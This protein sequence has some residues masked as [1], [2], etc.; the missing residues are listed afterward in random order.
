MAD[1]GDAMQ[2][3]CAGSFPSNVSTWG[4][5]L[6]VLEQLVFV[7]HQLHSVAHTRLHVL[8]RH[9]SGAEDPK[10][11]QEMDLLLLRL[12]RARGGPDTEALTPTLAFYLYLLTG[13]LY[14]LQGNLKLSFNALERALSATP[15]PGSA[16]ETRFCEYLNIRL[17]CLLGASL[18]ELRSHWEIFVLKIHGG[19]R[20]SDIAARIWTD[21]ILDNVLSTIAHERTIAFLALR[22]LPFLSNTHA[23]I[24]MGAFCLKLRRAALLDRSFATD[25][26]H[27]VSEVMHRA[28]KA[29]ND[30]PNADQPRPAHLDLM[31]VVYESLDALSAGNSCS[32]LLSREYSRKYLVRM[33]ELSFQ[34][35]AVLRYLIQ[36]LLDS[37]EY[38]E[39]FAAFET[40]VE[41]VEQKQKC[42]GG[43]V[44][45]ILA[46][47]D[48]Y[49]S[50]IC[51]FNPLNSFIP[52]AGVSSKRFQHRTL[53][54]VTLQL[55]THCG[56]L[57]TYLSRASQLSALVYL[58]PDVDESVDK[59]LA[60][61]YFRFNPNAIIG[62]D[63]PLVKSLCHAWFALGQFH[64]FLA[65]HNSNFIDDMKI[66]N[67][68]MLQYYSNSLLLNCTANSGHLYEY[69]LQLAYMGCLSAA[70]TLCK[71]ILKRHPELFRAW[72]LLVLA[73]SGLE[74]KE[75]SIDE[76]EYTPVFDVLA[77]ASLNGDASPKTSGTER[78]ID[79][80]LSVAALYMQKNKDS[81]VEAPI[82]SRYDILQL[83]MTQLSVWENK[84]GV[85][86]ILAY[87]T[88]VFVLYKELFLDL[89]G[90]MEAK[91][92]HNKFKSRPSVMDPK[93]LA[94]QQ[95]LSHKKT[96]KTSKVDE[97]KA[98]MNSKPSNTEKASNSGKPKNCGKPHS[99]EQKI[100]QELWLWTAS[101]YL[102]LDLLDEAEQC[103]V[104]AETCA[105][106]NVHT[107][108]Y[109]G[110]LTLK[111]RKFLALQEFERSLE[112]F[113]LPEQQFNRRAYLHT[114][115]GMCKLFIVDDDK[116]Q[117]LFISSKDN[118]VGLVRMKI[119]LEELSYC[120]PYGHNS[121]EL[122]YYLSQ[123]Y[124]TF[125]DKVLCE[126]A[127]WKCIELEDFRPVRSFDI[128]ESLSARLY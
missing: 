122:W 2:T 35:T 86:Y 24:A 25:Y 89:V 27:Y 58:S 12:E 43:T 100:L 29:K 109:L 67:Q 1:T 94:N 126:E 98:L 37:H 52:D 54:D 22:A 59:H 19:R 26:T 13:H 8:H 62:D 123:L 75:S 72:N 48:T 6:N 85:D 21:A 88:D 66:N 45:D 63:S 50:C 83:K 33:A 15:L 49:S 34:D 97:S 61:L 18:P 115:L 10:V 117:S 39:A 118:N 73:L 78:F 125:D 80:A 14:N 42:K 20:R 114:L 120:W 110:L 16:E 104:E 124:E 106:P 127:L 81:G 108:T 82:E 65:M 70:A 90:F 93:T 60:F 38:D 55:K 11:V 36:T 95:T 46:V 5:S 41:Y 9:E 44:D 57:Q 96:H 53:E 74:N 47:V 105:K 51:A 128:C 69:A 91:G 30:F 111:T 84:H 71:F 121:A 79:D 40:Y 17:C 107:F 28:S 64:S 4:D 87:I 113:H 119:Y 103:I 68:L 116:N 101:I 23:L 56:R 112:V 102:K 31:D 77:D 32:R 3:L 76:T 92:V 99:K 7:D